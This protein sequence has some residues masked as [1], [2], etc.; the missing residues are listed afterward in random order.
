MLQDKA[1]AFSDWHRHSGPSEEAGTRIRAAACE[2]RKKR[3]RPADDRVLRKHP[4]PDPRGLSRAIKTHFV[5]N[6]VK[7]LSAHHCFKPLQQL[8]LAKMLSL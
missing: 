6:P 5:E 8:K 2:V 1:S 7:I 4:Y 3:L